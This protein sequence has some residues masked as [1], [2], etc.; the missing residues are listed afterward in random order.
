MSRI[1]NHLRAAIAADGLDETPRAWADA[2]AGLHL[3]HRSDR[4]FHPKMGA[5]SVTMND[6]QIRRCCGARHRPDAHVKCDVVPSFDKRIAELHSDCVR[7][8]QQGFCVPTAARFALRGEL[9][10]GSLSPS[11]AHVAELAD[12]LL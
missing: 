11:S 4:R 8:G 9:K 1:Q 5:R 10:L 3:P 12:A 2:V 7:A 6:S